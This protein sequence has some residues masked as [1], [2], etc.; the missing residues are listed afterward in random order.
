MK[1][2]TSNAF[3]CNNKLFSYLFFRKVLGRVVLISNSLCLR[4]CLYGLVSDCPY[5]CTFISFQVPT[6][7]E[8]RR[9]MRASFCNNIPNRSDGNITKSHVENTKIVPVRHIIIS[10]QTKSPAYVSQEP[11]LDSSAIRSRTCKESHSQ[12]NVIQTNRNKHPEF[13]CQEDNDYHWIIS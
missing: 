5:L 11:I 13:V 12:S 7:K 10:Q 6:T 4:T 3:R 1:V 8:M 2:T 9:T